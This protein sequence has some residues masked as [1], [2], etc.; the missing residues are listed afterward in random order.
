MKKIQIAQIGVGH[1]HAL[2]V[3][4]N[5]LKQNDL[6]EVV[7][8]AVP[9]C[10]KETF[11]DRIETYKKI[12]PLKSVDEI[13]NDPEIQA[14]LIETEEVN[15]TKYALMAAEKGLHI[16]MDKPGGTDL[17]L[18][19]KLIDTAKKNGCVFHTGYMYR[20]NSNI[21]S[22]MEKIKNGDLGEIYSVEAQ[23]SCWHKKEK[24]QWLERFPGGM[25][26]YLGC[27]LI[28]IIVRIQGIPDEII[29]LSVST[30]AE[31]TTAKDFGMA[32]LKYKNG[33][34]FAK[35][36]ASECGGFNR[37][38]VVIAGT[39]GTIEIKPLE[40]IQNGD[41]TLL[42]SD[43]KEVSGFEWHAKGETKTTAPYDRY[44]AMMQAFS[45]YVHGEAKNPWDYDYELQ[46]FK[47]LLNAC[48]EPVEYV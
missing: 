3:L 5:V 8:F 29:P 16:H 42:Y 9:E 37:R 7:G 14:V 30:G 35:T 11:S 38:Q 45:R 40:Y 15:L 21:L 33:V 32:V 23:M 43:K 36:T 1:D 10:E 46:L 24:K 28:D 17:A 34:S 44:D 18:F 31:G 22:A 6:F 39:K 25:L 27:H 41:E 2:V 19:Q 12:I 26:F 13:L 47:I 20:Y 4:D 48:G